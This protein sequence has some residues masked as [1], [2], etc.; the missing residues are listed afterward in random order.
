MT[1]NEAYKLLLQK[2]KGMVAVA[3]YEYAN[4]YVFR[5]VSEKYKDT[6][7]RKR[8]LNGEYSVNKITREVRDFKPWHIPVDEYRAG[9]EIL[10]FNIGE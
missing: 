7:D 6:G 10:D 2:L 1:S 9:V 3:C 4:I 5:V 8:I